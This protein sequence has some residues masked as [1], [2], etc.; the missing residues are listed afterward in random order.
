MPTQTT[1]CPTFT[2]IVTSDETWLR[3]WDLV[4]KQESMHWKHTNWPPP[5][6]FHTQPSSGTVMATIFWDCKGVLLMDY[7]PHKTTMTGSYY[8][9]LLKNCFRQFR[10]NGGKCWPDVHCCCTTVHRLMHVSSCTSHS[11]GHWSW[12]AVS[13]TL[14]N[15][16]GT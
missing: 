14:L 16:P 4:T 7:L 8:G 15:R 9:E 6:K 3:H 11:Q 13:S 5:R 2:H 12:T 10:R 1:F